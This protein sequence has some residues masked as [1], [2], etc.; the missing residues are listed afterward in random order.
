MLGET[1]CFNACTLACCAMCLSTCLVWNASNF[2]YCICWAVESSILVHLIPLLV[3]NPVYLWYV[4]FK[5]L[6]AEIVHQLLIGWG[7][8]KKSEHNNKKNSQ[9]LGLSNGLSCLGVLWAGPL[10]GI[11]SLCFFSGAV[12][13]L[14]QVCLSSWALR[15]WQ[16]LFKRADITW[17]SLVVP[18][19]SF[20]LRIISDGNDGAFLVMSRWLTGFCVNK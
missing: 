3:V 6:R 8:G 14:E 17:V 16:I 7:K 5:S 1:V 13:P 19:V 18:G 4:D 9:A 11:I 15:I 2:I 20:W 12:I 10:L